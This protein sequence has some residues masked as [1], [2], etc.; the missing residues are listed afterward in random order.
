MRR[1][2]IAGAVIAL[3]LVAVPGAAGK[4]HTTSKTLD[5]GESIRVHG[6]DVRIRNLK[7]RIAG[8][9]GGSTPIAGYT[10]PRR[11]TTRIR[12]T[13]FYETAIKMDI[14]VGPHRAYARWHEG[15]GAGARYRPRVVVHW[16][17]T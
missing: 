13:F 15:T 7:V 16:V 12:T 6:K 1:L 4:A 2:T 14:R 8:P 5:P 3:G 11:G 9:K 17:D 10:S